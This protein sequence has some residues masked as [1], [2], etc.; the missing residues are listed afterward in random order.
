M[1]SVSVRLEGKVI[2]AI[3]TGEMTME[4]VRD[5]QRRIEEML[6][7]VDK[8]FVLYDTLAMD[9]PPIRLAME[10]KAFDHRVRTRVV[11]SAT[12]VRDPGTAFMAKVAF[13][14]S[15]EH[16]VFYHDLQAAYD[17]LAGAGRG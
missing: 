12:V 8:P 9:A 13:A 1:A 17:W 15:R 11:R 2:H 7:Q 10:M 16:R 14:L 6:G 4:L 3:Y 5:G